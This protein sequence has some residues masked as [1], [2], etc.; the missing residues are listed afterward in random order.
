MDASPSL[1]PSNVILRN[2][3]LLFDDPLRFVVVFV[4]SLAT[5]GIALLIGITVHEFSHAALAHR[6]G[7][8]TARRLGRLSL[9]P[10]RHLDPAGT[11]LL[12]LVGFG[13]G[14]PVPVNPR[15]LGGDAWKG[16]SIVAA[17]GPVSNVMTAAVC[18]VPIRLGLV[19]WQSPF[20]FR[21]LQGQ[22]LDGLAADLLGFV[23]FYNIILAVFN[24]IPLFPL[25]GSK[26][27]LGI[28]PPRMA[29]RMARFEASGPAILIMIIAIDMITDL[30]LLWRVLNPLV[31]VVGWMVMARAL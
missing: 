22:G 1:P 13:W 30:N 23:I 14:K 15:R 4:T 26:V 31:D 18:A 19:D 27:A 10:V 28:L 12:L 9:N 17:A 20:Y 16:M 7:D 11:I 25:D 29:A 24:L 8:D 6:L 3:D 5:A 21:G 2:I